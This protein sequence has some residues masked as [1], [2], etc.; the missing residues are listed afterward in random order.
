M[1]R[2]ILI[3]VVLCAYVAAYAQGIGTAKDL[4]AFILAYNNGESVMQWCDADSTVCLSADIDMSKAKNL[5][6]IRSFKGRFDG[7]GFR[8]RNWKA[9][10]G[11]FLDIAA[12]GLV[13]NLVI[14]SS[15]SLKSVGKGDEHHA[16]FIADNNN[17]VIRDCVN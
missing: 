10:R 14:D 3:F 17:G 15:C 7:K 8:L 4:Q 6:Q 12:T 5:P 9:T 16:G 1:K 11:L 2:I 13:Q